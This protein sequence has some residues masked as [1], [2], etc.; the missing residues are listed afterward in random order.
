MVR[1]QGPGRPDA[2]SDWD[3]AV[4]FARRPSLLEVG[5]LAAEIARLIG[6]DRVDILV[7]DYPELPPALLYE[8]YW[9]GKPF[10]IIDRELYLWDK[11]RALS[12]YH[13]YRIALYPLAVRMLQ[14]LAKR[15]APKKSEEV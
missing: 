5:A 12:L 1:E 11:V 6:N 2:L 10:C 4:R 7:L 13:D 8:V 14:R 9:R 15:E 3:F